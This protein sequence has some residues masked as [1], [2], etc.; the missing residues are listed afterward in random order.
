MQYKGIHVITLTVQKNLFSLKFAVIS[1]FSHVIFPQLFGDFS[2]LF[3]ISVA[4]L[5]NCCTG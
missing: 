4:V 3:I 1:K 5:F 2:V